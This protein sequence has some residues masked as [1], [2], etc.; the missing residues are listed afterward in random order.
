VHADGT[1]FFWLGDT[2]WNGVLR[3][4]EGEWGEFLAERVRQGFSVIQIFS[5][6]WRGFTADGLGETAFRFG[7]RV[8]VNPVFF[9]RL[10][11]KVRA[12][13]EN[14][15]LVYAI[16]VLAL[17]EDEPAWAWSEEDLVRFL[18]YLEARWGAYHM[19]WSPVGDGEYAG[20]RAER[21]K[22]VCREVYEAPHRN[23]VTLHPIGWSLPVDEFRGE[24]WFDFIA[25]Q[26][27]HDD[28]AER[29]RWHPCG[30]VAEEWRNRPPRPIVNVEFNYEGHPSFT[31]GVPFTERDVRRA[32]Y[33][34][35]LISP[36]AGLSYGHYHEF[37]WSARPE[38]IGPAIPLPGQSDH[39]AGPWWQAV[40][41]PGARSMTA[42]RRFFESGPWWHLRPAP[43]M[44]EA[45][46]G[47][48]D[49]ARFVAVSCTTEGDWTVA[50]LPVGGEIAIRRALLPPSVSARW[51]DPRSGHWHGADE[52]STPASPSA[53]G[54]P[55][56]RWVAPDERDWVLDLRAR[57]N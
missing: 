20:A 43:Q 9:R 5:A 47:L 57:A 21:L 16:G 36:P 45:Q 12:V 27:G 39:L 29:V 55:V 44:L 10:D 31:S 51:F 56:S 4:E 54:D 28:A 26:S 48:D 46:P 14:G 38:R 42:L 15:M 17:L 1:P 34:S 32:A 35:L 3:A 24:P 53:S 52:P 37:S 33:W 49:A 13:N 18:R 6:T 11:P 23:L 2:V 30:P 25:Y 8:G 41:A 50:Y 7:H 40:D 19:V 22:R